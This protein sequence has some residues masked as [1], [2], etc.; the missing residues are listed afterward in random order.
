M[1]SVASPNFRLHFTR[2]GPYSISQLVLAGK[3]KGYDYPTFLTCCYKLLKNTGDILYRP[4]LQVLSVARQALTRQLLVA[5][6]IKVV[7][8]DAQEDDLAS[9]VVHLPI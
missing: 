5:Q 2:P 1:L 6:H 3:Q 8:S 7:V 4:T 9:P